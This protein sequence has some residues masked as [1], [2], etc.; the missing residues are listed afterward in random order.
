M[1]KFELMERKLA[2]EARINQGSLRRGT[3]EY[4]DWKNKIYPAGTRLANAPIL[5]DDSASPHTVRMSSRRFR[6]LRVGRN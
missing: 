6:R 2:G 4:S 3:I 1:S 5:I